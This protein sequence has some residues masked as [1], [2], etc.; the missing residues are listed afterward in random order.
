MENSTSNFTTK[1]II[2]KIMDKVDKIEVFMNDNRLIRETN[3]VKTEESYKKLNYKL[4]NL[5][6]NVNDKFDSYN[7]LHEKQYEFD[8][9]LTDSM[10]TV[11]ETCKKI[12]KAHTECRY[13]PINI[14]KKK[15]SRI[16]NIGIYLGLI[17]TFLTAVIGTFTIY[18]YIVE[19]F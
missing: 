12:E 13:N 11:E 7:G 1:D 8:T 15:H 5:T 14:I 6:K 16:K 10:K 17:V 4:D 3:Q 19:L 2:I 18:N 9:K